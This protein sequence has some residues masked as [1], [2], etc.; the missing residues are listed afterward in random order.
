MQLSPL[1]QKAIIAAAALH[2][3]QKRK[4]DGFPFV[5]HPYSVAIILSNYTDNEEVLA[6]GLLHDVL[7]EAKGYTE[8]NL[9]A[10]FG[11][12]VFEIVKEASEDRVSEE[13][14]EDRKASWQA[15]KEKY[16]ENLKNDSQ[17]ALM[18]VCADK[19]HNLRSMMSAYK[20]QGEE[21]WDKFNAPK[22][23]ILWYYQQVLLVL[24]N[25]LSNEIVLE[26]RDSFYEAR[27]LFE[28]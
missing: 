24:E 26:F 2:T 17:E 22:D 11:R 28:D 25:R 27:I 9:E 13:K 12:N 8:E 6:A 19:I 14:D 15:R 7:E 3:R 5:V 1:V 18:V 16:L 21:F 4:G 10:D 20:S 23:K